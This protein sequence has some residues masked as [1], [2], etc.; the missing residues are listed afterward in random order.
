MSEPVEVL[1]AAAA[2]LRERAGAVSGGPW[3][4]AVSEVGDGYCVHDGGFELAHGME[5][6]EAA[7]VAALHPGV[8]VL[9]ADVLDE[10]AAAAAETATGIYGPA[11]AE[12][13]Y[14]GDNPVLALARAVLEA[15]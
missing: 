15:K 3:H 8:A 10:E 11:G 1:R 13:V 9:L 12:F 5:R 14:G 7:Y 2:L 6:P 4:F